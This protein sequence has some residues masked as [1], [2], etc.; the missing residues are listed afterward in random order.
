V[1]RPMTLR[2]KCCGAYVVL[3]AMGR[4]ANMESLPTRAVIGANPKNSQV[5]AGV[6]VQAD[7]A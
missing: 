3:D 1:K 7:T 4:K 6:I 5:G 2:E